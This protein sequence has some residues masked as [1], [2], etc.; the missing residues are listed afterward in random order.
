MKIKRN[1]SEYPYE[2]NFFAEAYSRSAEVVYPDGTMVCDSDAAH[3]PDVEEAVRAAIEAGEDVY[4]EVAG[5]EVGG[6]ATFGI[7]SD[8]YAYT[9]I[10]VSATGHKV[11]LQERSSK[12]TKDSDYFGDQR[13]VTYENLEG[14]KMVATRRTTK[15]GVTYRPKGSSC[16]TVTFGAARRY[17]DPSF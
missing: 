17:T 7:G 12:P 16:G 8:S 13:Y 15:R 10:E 5:P 4:F 3:D 11:V 2:G 14:S 6:L 1:A 9:V